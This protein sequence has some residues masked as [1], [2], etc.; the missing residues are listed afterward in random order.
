MFCYR[1]GK[2]E[3]GNVLRNVVVFDEARTVFPVFDNPQIGYASVLNMVQ[4]L[5]EFGVAIIAADSTAQLHNILYGNT[6]LKVLMPLGSGDDLLKAAR[7][8]GL[9]PDQAQASHGLGVGEAIVRDHR[10]NKVFVLE[11]PKFPL[12]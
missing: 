1:I 12:E 4:V 2:G 9:S 7:A 5:R 8:M 3:R 6:A 10:V 11:I